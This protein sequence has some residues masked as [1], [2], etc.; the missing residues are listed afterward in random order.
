M[1]A[2]HILTYHDGEVWLHHGTLLYFILLF[3][4]MVARG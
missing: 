3:L 1:L 4:A 2:I